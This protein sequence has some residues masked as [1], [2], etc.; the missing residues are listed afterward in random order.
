MLRWC[1]YHLLV[2]AVLGVG[3]LAGCVQIGVVAFVVAASFGIELGPRLFGVLCVLGGMP[4]GVW[5]LTRI[6]RWWYSRRPPS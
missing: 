4:L 6:E 2:F 5:Q 1:I 3:C